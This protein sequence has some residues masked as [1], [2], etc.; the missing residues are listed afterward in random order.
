MS[1]T[2]KIC[3]LVVKLLP[4]EV[5]VGNLTYFEKTIGTENTDLFEKFYI[6]ISLKSTRMNT[7]L[8]GN[9]GVTFIDFP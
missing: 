6:I 9:E 7:Y 1:L 5:I 8:C 4:M 3:L 2:V